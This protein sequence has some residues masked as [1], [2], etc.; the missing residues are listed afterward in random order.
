MGSDRHQTRALLRAHLSAAARAGHAMRSCAVC[1]RLQ[2][3]AMQLPPLGPGTLAPRLPP[4]RQLPW[5][6]AAEG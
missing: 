3:Q 6:E 4:V 5:P 2:R 1:R